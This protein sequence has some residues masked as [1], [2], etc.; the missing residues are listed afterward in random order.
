M[1]SN[2]TGAILPKVSL[3]CMVLATAIG[4]MLVFLFAAHAQGQIQNTVVECSH[5][6]NQSLTPCCT[7]AELLVRGCLTQNVQLIRQPPVTK[8]TAPPGSNITILVNPN[9]PQL[10]QPPPQLIVP[11]VGPPPLPPVLPNG[12]LI[13]PIVPL[14]KTIANKDIVNLTSALKAN[15]THNLK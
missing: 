11:P 3:I 10:V 14:L 4:F 12:T 2:K 7:S 13:D 6:A 8:F 9:Q 5:P 15:Q 1:T